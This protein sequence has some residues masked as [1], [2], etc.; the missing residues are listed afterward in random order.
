MNCPKCGKELKPGDKFCT[1]CGAP[2]G[3]S[4]TNHQAGMAGNVH[5]SANVS[6]AQTENQGSGIDL[7]KSK[8][9]IRSYFFGFNDLMWLSA[10]VW[11]IFSILKGQFDS[12]YYYGVSP[13]AGLCGMIKTLAA[14]LFCVSIVLTIYIRVTGAGEK[15][16]DTA[17]KN[18]IEMLKARALH[19][20]HVDREQI[21]EVKP[22]QIAG[23]GEKPIGIGIGENKRFKIFKL[24]SKLFTNDPIE[25]YRMERDGMP[26]Y[27]LVQV[28][29]YAFTDT[30]MS[31][32]N[33]N[34]DISTGTVY[35][36][37][38][39]EIFY[40]DVNG[41]TQVDRLKKFKT[42]IFRTRYYTLKFVDLDICGITKTASFD[43]RIVPDAEESI[44]GMESYIREKKF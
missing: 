7:L 40:K 6:A 43:S 12:A 23:A 26:R 19:R 2:I 41:V 24:M 9:I 33:G 22:I 14:I 18:S 11:I 37:H 44:T 1:G 30:Q 36:E 29:V 32:Y 28:T 38:V 25:G 35:E 27:L 13:V 16:V 39:A 8:L 10:V 42:G 4:T 20:F 15:N 3:N 17:T 21:S 34:V 31:V 5:C